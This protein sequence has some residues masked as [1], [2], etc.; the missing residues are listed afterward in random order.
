[1]GLLKSAIASLIGSRG[2]AAGQARD[3]ALAGDVPDSDW[4]SLADAG[5]LPEA[6]TFIDEALATAPDDAALRF[7]RADVL[8][9]WG[10]DRE[11]MLEIRRACATV[12]GGMEFARRQAWAAMRE[13]RADEAI[14]CHRRVLELDPSDVAATIGL[15]TALQ[16][17]GRLDEAVACFR[18]A[19]ARAPGDLASLLAL[20]S[21]E[22]A[23]KRPTDAEALF[24]RAVV[25]APGSAAAHEHHG[26]ALAALD[27]HDEALAALA[28]A[29]NIARETGEPVDAYANV[30]IGL[31]E[32]GHAS[33][34]IRVLV[35]GLRERP[36]LNGFLQLGPALLSLGHFRAGWRY[37]E[38]RW[39][40][41]PF[42]SM[43]ADYGVPH[44]MGQSL[45]GRTILVR[46]EQGLG[47][48]FQFVRY[49]PLLK[50]R[51]AR[52]L[53]QPLEG[54]DAI[55]RRFPGIDH[56]LADGERLP[57][58]DFC[59]NLMSLPLAFGTT[60]ATIPAEVPYLSPDPAYLAK[61]ASRFADR[62]R[63]RVG[64]AWAGRPTHR[65]DRLRSM[66]LDQLAS[67]LDVEGVRF[68]SLQKGPAAAQA[69]AVPER[70]D[71]DGIGAELDDLDDAAAV[72]SGLDLLIAVDT[73]LAHLAGAMGKPVWVMLQ[74]PSEYRWMT[75]R[76]DTPWYPTMRLFRQD[77]PRAWGA[78]VAR[79]AESLREWVS[80]PQ[81]GTR[82]TMPVRGV[83]RTPGDAV[84]ALVEPP[85][86]GLAIAAETR[87]GFLQFVP[88]EPRIGRSL[89]HYG[90]WLQPRLDV[91]LRFVR[92][93]AVLVEAGAGAGAHTLPL[94]RAAGG[95]GTLLAY[96]SRPAFRR[97]LAQNLAAHRIANVSVMARVIGAD[98]FA[99]GSESIDDLGLARLDG[100]KVNEG[101][102]PVAIL[103][104][105]G[106]TL[107][108]CRPWL[109][110]GS[111]DPKELEPVRDALRE[112]GYRAWRMETPL[113]APTNYNRRAEDAFAGEMAH[114]LFA[115]P[116]EV[117]LR[118]P[119]PGCG[120]W[121]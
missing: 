65:S 31:C 3:A 114:A 73:G 30:G 4:R 93:G 7:A 15:G 56:I 47:D 6:L 86:A 71:W 10:R 39:L 55:A 38:H 77:T 79:V 115:L 8:K 40:A 82:P 14:A 13:G 32:T 118:A 105:A 109:L 2:P 81:R 66:H 111:A 57:A 120:E 16:A 83:S 48:M 74:T 9:A 92:P 5:R 20:G 33:E 103:G 59:A 76:E 12:S 52:V 35:D 72:L 119:L 107:W 88:D 97:L 49:L 28:Q 34:A 62:S 41:E 98:R 21:C 101:A 11:A 51:G 100:I 24:R 90:E 27:R 87:S 94:A 99:S 22:L 18:D 67:I 17:L 70:V 1:M 54:L 19:Q 46:S 116:E 36:N 58:L 68:V 104:G 84:G 117:D 80:D 121:L 69:E 85:C 44:W 60:V 64:L 110:V 63:P 95:E 43:R 45:E 26:I 29:E 61:W 89:E 91:A 42:A 102:D 37:Y 112:F 50:A 75:G 96:E 23:R 78:V 53:F 113:H 106:S 108:R 25:L